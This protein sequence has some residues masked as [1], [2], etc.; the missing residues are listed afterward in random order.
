MPIQLRSISP[1]DYGVMLDPLNPR[2]SSLDQIGQERHNGDSAQAA[3]IDRN[4]RM[5]LQMLASKSCV[6]RST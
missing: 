4:C 3:S 2:R 6:R 1:P 5:V